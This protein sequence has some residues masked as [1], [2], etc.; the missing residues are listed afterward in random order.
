MAAAINLSR[1]KLLEKRKKTR[2]IQKS[3][4][5]FL[6]TSALL[7]V[8]STIVLFYYV[9]SLMQEEVEE[10]L[11]STESRIETAL[12]ENKPPYELPPIVEIFKVQKLEA[13]IVKDTLI[14][15]PF[16]N[17]LEEFRELS[18]FKR[19]KGQNY[20]IT[21][22]NLIV[23]S[24]DILIA[25]VVS[26]AIIIIL[27]F[28]VLYYFNRLWSKKLW[29]PFFS[30][31][32]QMKKF[33]MLS[34]T[35]MQLIDSDI[36][37]FSELNKEVAL[38]T[39]KVK[40]DY[41]N[42]KQFTEDVSHELQNPLAIIQAKIE[43]IINGNSLNEIQFERLTSIQKDI[44]RL[45]QMNKRLTLLTKIENKQFAKIEKVNITQQMGETIQNFQEISLKKIRFKNIKEI[46][47]QMDPYLA[48]ILCNNL[49]SNAIKY[50]L[51][52]GE[53]EVLTTEKILSISNQGTKALEHPE[54]LYSR[55]YKE[56]ETIKSTGLGLAIVNRIC[57]LY[58]FEISYHFKKNQH[59]FSIKF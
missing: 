50:S 24:E 43:N 2:L 6:I 23:E 59:V 9:K 17:E 53:I 26:Y 22:R 16:Q 35:P 36:L 49:I 54:K 56:S 47:V 8:L 29:S 48:E 41:K 30:T 27:V 44:Q 32:E 34:E 14:F 4:K 11:F 7:M 1:T 28:L 58:H 40:T 51:K 20:K 52:E 57:E 21:V 3:S 5:T 12:S 19:I 13:T 46:H 39:N 38:L 18:S 25:V 15:D 33:S 42:L 37:E 45:G 55:F 31:L 10:E